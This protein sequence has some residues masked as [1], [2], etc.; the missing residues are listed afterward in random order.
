[1]TVRGD[2][3]IIQQPTPTAAGIPVIRTLKWQRVA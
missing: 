3:L 1:M 2:E